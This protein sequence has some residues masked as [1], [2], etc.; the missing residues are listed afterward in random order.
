ME[1]MNCVFIDRTN[2][3]SAM[4]SIFEMISTLQIGH[5][6]IIFLEGTRSKK[7]GVQELKSGFTK[8]A[9]GADVPIIPIAFVG[10]SYI[11]ENNQYKIKTAHV[12]IHVLEAIYHV[13][14]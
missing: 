12:D 13:N 1:A 7:N 6:M 5:S 2:R 3:R 11:M 4:C 8:I 14:K 10:T 9:K